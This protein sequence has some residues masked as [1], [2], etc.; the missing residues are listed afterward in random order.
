MLE[1]RKGIIFDLDGTMVDSMWMWRQIDME[2]MAGRNLEFTEQ[3]Q[4]NIEGMSFRETAEYFIRT[5]PIT[6]SVEDLMKIWIDMAKDKYAHEVLLKPGIEKF[7]QEA[8]KLGIKMGI[9]TSNA[10][11]LLDVVAGKYR[12]Y[13]YIDAVLTANEVTR[14]KPAPDVYLAV[15]G[16]L[17]LEPK[18]CLV[19]EDIPAGIRAG[20]AAGMRVCAVEDAY[21]A[22][23]LD[24]KKK[25][26]HYYITSYD[27]ILD[28][29]YEV[30]G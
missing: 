2:F 8:K 30:L 28:H 10:R 12:F 6:E 1:N 5:Y 27:Q 25:L 11:E 17:G 21:S 18:D 13:D 26:A 16:K 4:Q 15:A 14:G 3:L 7:L 19:F 29:T 9:A 22:G 24:Q 20:L 23:L